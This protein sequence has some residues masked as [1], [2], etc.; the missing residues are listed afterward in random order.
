MLFW[1]HLPVNSCINSELGKSNLKG[2]KKIYLNW[3]CKRSRV[4]RKER[5]RG[6]VENRHPLTCRDVRGGRCAVRN[7][8]YHKNCIRSPVADSGS[9]S[10]VPCT[11]N[12][13]TDSLR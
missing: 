6:T 8:F 12:A 3:S 2:N 7:V 9:A 4:V 13:G 1:R 10:G 5:W 11:R